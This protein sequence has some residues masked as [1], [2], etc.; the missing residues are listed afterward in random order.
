MRQSKELRDFMLRFYRSESAR[1]FF[2]NASGVLFIGTDPAEWWAGFETIDR[3]FKADAH[4]QGPSY[5]IEPGQMQALEEGR[6]GWVADQP[7]LHL[8]NG[9]QVRVRVT[10]V[11]HRERGAWRIVQHHV[12]V[13]VPNESLIRGL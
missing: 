4:A 7:T 6:V 11:L 10:T 12:S 9:H 5:A 13:A 8:P 1:G 3:M 2:S